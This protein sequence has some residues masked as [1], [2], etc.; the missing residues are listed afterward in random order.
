LESR[1]SN[2]GFAKSRKI[3][4]HRIM[5]DLSH[6]SRWRRGFRNSK[7]GVSGGEEPFC[8][9][10]RKSQNPEERKEKFPKTLKENSHGPNRVSGFRE[11]R[12]RVAS[13]H[14]SRNREERKYESRVPSISQRIRVTEAER[15]GQASGK[16]PKDLRSHQKGKFW[17]LEN[18]KGRGTSVGRSLKF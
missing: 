1:V 16:F 6:R 3:Q 5:E 14:N 17:K 8:C 15:G 4:I 9:G 12:D 18:H 10:S 7:I 2:Y 11:S 13:Q